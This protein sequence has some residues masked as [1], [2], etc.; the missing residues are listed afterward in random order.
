MT[1]IATPT[2]DYIPQ[3]QQLSSQ[4]SISTL[5]A[6]RN[7]KDINNFDYSTAA[8]PEQMGMELSSSVEP[9]HIN[10]LNGQIKDEQ[11][12][13]QNGRDNKFK[14]LRSKL[15]KSILLRSSPNSTNSP[16]QSQTSDPST[17]PPSTNSKLEPSI[18]PTEVNIPTTSN[19]IN[20]QTQN[21]NL[22]SSKNQ[23]RDENS[24]EPP[25]QDS[26]IQQSQST[27]NS[28]I[29]NRSQIAVSSSSQF[30]TFPVGVLIGRRNVR[31]SMLVR[32]G[33]DG[34]QV[35]EFEKWLLPYNEVIKILQFNTQNLPD[36]RVELRSPTVNTRIS[37]K[38]LTKDPKLGLAFSIQDLKK[39]F[40]VSANF[41]LKDYAI[42]L[43]I[44]Q[45][46]R[47][48]YTEIDEKPVNLEGLPTLQAPKFSLSTVS[49]R[50]T[51]QGGESQSLNWRGDASAI[52]TAF[53][54]SWF[55]RTERSQIQDK[56]KWNLAEAQ[57]LRQTE[58]ADYILGSQN[59]FWLNTE[60]TGSYWGFTTIQRQ[61]FVPS[62]SI[63]NL[64]PEQRLQA[65]Y[66][67]RTIT[68]KAEPGTLVQLVESFTNRL[69]DE[70]LVD[71]DGTYEFDN[72]AVRGK[73]PLN[74][75]SLYLYP[76]GRLAAQ[77]EIREVTLNSVP[78]QLPKGGSALIV[79]AGG[80]RQLTN[81][82]LGK[83][84]GFRGGVAKRWGVSEDLTLG[85]GAVHNGSARGLTEIYW[86]PRKS[87][88]SVAL[89]SLTPGIGGKKSNDWHFRSNVNFQPSTNFYAN[90]SSDFV[91]SRFYVNWRLKP[92]LSVFS[93]L[94]S[95]KA[96]KIGAQFIRSRKNAFTFA[97]LSVNTENKWQWNLLQRLGQVELFS[98]GNETRTNSELAYYFNP[99]KYS[100]KGH[101][102]VLGYETKLNSDDNDL[103]S[104]N[105]RYRS[106]N[107]TYGG[108]PV[109]EAELGYGVGSQ[110]SGLL[111]AV[112][113]S[114]LPGLKLRGRY[115]G[116]SLTS[117]QSA[118]R[119]E[120]LP[121]LNLQGGIRGSR[122]RDRTLRS[123][124]GILLQAFFDQNANG[125]RDSGEK[126]YRDD[127]NLLVSLNNQ[128]LSSAKP[129][130]TGSRTSINLSPGKYRL[131]LDPAGFPIDW[132]TSTSAYAVEV[133]AGS[134]T[135]VSIPLVPAYTISGVIKD[136]RGNALAGATVEAIDS[137][138]GKKHLSITNS[139]GVY[140]L[141]HLMQG[142]YH[143]QIN[144]QIL[145]R[146]MVK[147]NS[148]SQNWQKLNININQHLSSN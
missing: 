114:I 22:S 69:I 104:L 27:T 37:L 5:Q 26:K 24:F 141:E 47:R 99:N 102:L 139:A 121:S 55:L 36:G 95:Q 93:L 35:I 60:N 49:Q 48:V 127:L 33:E 74:K 28:D 66:L 64:S 82:F 124:G 91:R 130:T 31:Q 29:G 71:S 62:Q 14:L 109:W 73:I 83:F 107:Q 1:D 135:S 118:F 106:K 116:A 59:P 67:G 18:D 30:R 132:Q 75:Y 25:F 61:G 147:L 7:D 44:P 97:S 12:N 20:F 15:K 100:N 122:R 8:P 23:F 17:T 13:T 133:V 108:S 142:N 43:E 10:K 146:K 140:Y 128:S 2:Q 90:F 86:Q 85:L 32:G 52:G 131:D 56:Q 11:A 111:A 39:Y 70:V 88:L 19:S 105:W 9:Y 51:V 41:D 4:I 21:E 126:I 57:F 136:K 38:E 42:R 72:V 120:F 112:S 96:A 129:E 145:P 63:L 103:L 117:D 54:G 94:D 6:N 148:N 68:G 115:Q 87:A 50:L 119:L 110:G 98:N 123:E 113:T 125:K 137:Q 144:G 78:G 143:L 45:S 46:N 79:S 76:Q 134:Y 92:F 81:S 138:T 80:E 53:G 101:A 16:T 58:A 84:T 89:S 3:S 65:D 34:S 77:P 40:G